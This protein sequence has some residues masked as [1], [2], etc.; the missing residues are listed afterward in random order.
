M[1]IKMAPPRVVAEASSTVAVVAGQVRS[2]TSQVVPHEPVRALREGND[3]L[4]MDCIRQLHEHMPDAVFFIDGRHRI[5]GC[6]KAAV[7]MFGYEERELMGRKIGL[8]W[9][10][11]P[12]VRLNGRWADHGAVR[13]GLAITKSGV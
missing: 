2:G 5:S 12:N 1:S 10:P 9:H 7:A 4:R 8:V 13:A 11:T 6:N 3:G